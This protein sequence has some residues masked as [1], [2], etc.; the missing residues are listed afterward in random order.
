MSHLDEGTIHAL[1]DGEVAAAEAAGL[2][3]HLA[4]C[5][6][7]QARLN[8]ARGFR[9]EAFGLI[10]SLDEADRSEP[11]MMVAETGGRYERAA[12]AAPIDGTGPGVP[13][14]GRTDV[15]PIRS[16]L[17]GWV[18][19]VAWAATL[20]L[21]VGLGYSLNLSPEDSAVE[22][23]ER[24]AADSPPSAD[25]APQMTVPKESTPTAGTV[26]AQ[27]AAAPGARDGASSARQNAEPVS[28]PRPA[29][30][31]AAEAE[32]DRR[33][34][35]DQP[36]QPV[37]PAA[38][39]ASADSISPTTKDNSLSLEFRRRDSTRPAP[40]RLE[41]VTTAAPA[42][43]AARR[44]A[45]ALDRVELGISADSAIRML[46]GSIRL[47]DGLTPERYGAVD[48]LV[49]VWYR[50]PWGPLLLEQWRD[51][52]RIRHR[53]VAPIGAPVDSTGAWTERI[54]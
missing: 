6:E 40:A 17:P 16:A 41:E 9:D 52:D 31:P 43:G 47:I 3:H 44:L 39:K 30:S 45:A 35:S 49:R 37:Q 7:C 14:S 33:V 15:R 24:E 54:R 51:D 20:V 19:P 32:A 46:G 29:A 34:P 48:L 4:R 11:V 53:L 1:L 2:R 36:P 25:N 23:V 50:T 26:G 5:P 18:R 21:A 12:L 38:K 28:P 42:P 13:R 22:S 27:R 8:E 10:Q